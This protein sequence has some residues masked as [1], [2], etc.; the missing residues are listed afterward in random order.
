M[1]KIVLLVVFVFILCP[2]WIFIKTEPDQLAFIKVKYFL[3][4]ALVFLSTKSVFLCLFS[5]Y[6]TFTLVLSVIFIIFI[7]VF[8]PLFIYSLVEYQILDRIFP[9]IF[10][11]MWRSAF[12]SSYDI[13]KFV[14]YFGAAR[15][16]TDVISLEGL[17][18]ERYQ[19]LIQATKQAELY[20]RVYP[21]STPEE[22]SAW[23]DK[24]I[25]TLSWNHPRSFLCNVLYAGTL[26]PVLKFFKLVLKES[27]IGT[28]TIQSQLPKIR[29][30]P[31]DVATSVDSNVLNLPSESNKK[32]IG[33]KEKYPL[34]ESE[35]QSIV[36]AVS[37]RISDDEEAKKFVL[38][39]SE[40]QKAV[41]TR[42]ERDS[43][44]K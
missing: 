20:T 28:K 14:V 16:V 9:I 18:T 33:L 42:A 44:T 19:I 2:H 23:V 40:V 27:E 15:A 29:I 36:E 1:E 37:K 43:D 21:N 24:R 3:T 12:K 22:L 4:G 35:F 7:K 10:G 38:S 31:L 5:F 32:I 11:N 26:G 13:A 6:L 25:E 39:N 30:N 8:F 41:T 17:N 34:S